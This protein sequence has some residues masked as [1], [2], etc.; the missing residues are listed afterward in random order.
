MRQL[1]CTVVLPTNRPDAWFSRAVKSILGNDC[2]GFECLI[3]LDGVQAPCEDWAED[4]RVRLL[5]VEEPLGLAHALNK[6]VSAAQGQ[7]IARMDADD[8]A[9]CDRLR[10]QIDYLKANPET[11]AVGSGAR[12]IRANGDVTEGRIGSVVG[13][14]VRRHLLVR[15][16]LV[17]PSV[18]FRRASFDQVGGYN[19]AMPTME[20]YDLW[21][22]MARLGSIAV[23]PEALIDYRVH[24][25]QMSRGASWRGPHIKQIAKSRVRLAKELRV[26]TSAAV[27]VQLAWTARQWARSR[28]IVS[29]GYVRALAKA[30]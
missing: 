2:G 20:D 10:R 3:V 23:L 4:P 16:I 6:G 1:D 24:D 8:V 21:L 26:P 17:H 11:V 5:Y 19:Q 22:R 12:L 13:D 27:A 9:R 18:A 28:G 15:N 7:F 25:G 14:D 30:G 29:P